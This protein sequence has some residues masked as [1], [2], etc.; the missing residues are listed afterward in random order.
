MITRSEEEGGGGIDILINNAGVLEG[1]W[2]NA[3]KGTI[4]QLQINIQTNLYGVISTTQTFLPLLL[5]GD[6]KKIFTLSSLSGSIGGI[7]SE[8]SF[9]T[10]YCV[11]KAALNMWL[12]KLSRDLIGEGFTVIPIHPGYV[13]T[14]M[15]GGS[16]GNA[17]IF[18]D[19]SVRKM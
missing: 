8:S 1:G 7:L 13:K 12:V 5:K 19:E 11:S 3:I 18:P 15:N 16:G 6:Q 14:D 10:P 4:T 9:A 17:D 2:I